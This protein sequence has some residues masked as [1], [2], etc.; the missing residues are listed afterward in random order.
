M[1][2]ASA[3][4]H[5]SISVRKGSRSLHKSIADVTAVVCLALVLYPLLSVAVNGMQQQQQHSHWEVRFVRS[6]VS[7]RGLCRCDS[8]HASHCHAMKGCIDFS[9]SIAFAFVGNAITALMLLLLLLLL[10]L[11]SIEIHLRQPV[12]T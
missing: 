6:F 12:N 11:E 2:A 1:K 4:R 10:L 8:L 5:G 7:Q 9:T 3:G